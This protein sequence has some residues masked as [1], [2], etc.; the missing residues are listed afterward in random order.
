[1]TELDERARA[2]LDLAR[3]AHDPCDDDRVRVR[4]ALAARLGAVGGLGLAASLGSSAKAAAVAGAGGGLGAGATGS[5]VA[6]GMLAMK[7]IGAA[8]VVASAVGG[9]AAAVH[10][11]RHAHVA[12]VTAS[13]RSS[14]GR[15]E[16]PAMTPPGVSPAASA[17]NEETTPLAD[18]CDRCVGTAER[19]Q[20]PPAAHAAT[21]TSSPVAPPERSTHGEGHRE[22]DERRVGTIAHLPE[23][24]GRSAGKTAR[25]LTPAL[26]ALAALP[27]LADE[28]R[29]FQ[30]GVT[31]LRAGQPAR[32]LALF[33]GHAL[34]YPDG[35]LAEERAA[36]RVLA[37]A[38][39]GR[40]TEAHAAAEE[41]LRAHPASP[42]AARL[43]ERLRQLD[44]RNTESPSG[45]TSSR[46]SM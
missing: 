17:R 27:T 5:A 29:L 11:A 33:D 45:P 25:P 26:P 21:E 43:R 8:V 34:I 41:F 39:L 2:L 4:A 6:G 12:T 1:M 35:A 40:T 3:D 32:A 19:G 15:Y 23:G 36:E 9:G 24:V 18:G 37:L 42:L 28:A 20:A 30:D 22:G 7:L 13:A 10:H 38:D 14:A 46:P 16:A 31:A 44:A